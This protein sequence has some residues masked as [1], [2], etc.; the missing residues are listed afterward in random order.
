MNRI[1]TRVDNRLSTSVYSI[2]ISF[3]RKKRSHS[4][5]R[6]CSWKV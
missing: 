6:T 3:G 5:I 1:T 2:W 4:S